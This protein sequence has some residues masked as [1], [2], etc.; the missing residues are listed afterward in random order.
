MD[1]TNTTT[2]PDPAFR[3]ALQ[4]ALGATSVEATSVT[5][6][7]LSN[8]GITDITGIAN[9]TELTEFILDDNQIASIN[10]TSNN[11]L[12][13]LSIRNNR[14]TNGIN[15]TNNP[16]KLASGTPLEKFDATGCTNF[17]A[18]RAMSG[19][20]SIKTLKW[21]SLNGCVAMH[22]FS[23]G[24]SDQTGLKYLDLT[25]SGQADT[26]STDA[27]KL[28]Y[29]NSL[30][31]LI[32]LETLI[33]AN[34]AS[35][36]TADLTK[37]TK[38]KYLDM[39]G[40]KLGTAFNPAYPKSLE[41]LILANNSSLRYTN[42][43]GCENLKYLDMSGNDMYWGTQTNSTNKLTPANCP[44]LEVLILDDAKIATA[45]TVDGFQNLKTL[46]VGGS[47]NTFNSGSDLTL[48]NCPAIENINVSGAAN[49][50][51]VAIKN[52]GLTSIPTITSDGCTKLKTLVL[53]GN[54]FSDVPTVG[55]PFTCLS[56]Q[57]NNFPAVYSLSGNTLEGLDLG[58][59]GLTSVTVENSAMSA[60]SLAGNTNLTEVHLHGNANLTKTASDEGI[61]AA[62]GLYIKGLAN[63]ETLDIEN[64]SFE[65]LGQSN[66]TQGC[67][68][69]KT[70]K[71][72][73]NKFTT[74]SNAYTSFSASSRTKDESRSSLE[75]LTGLEYLDLSNNLL[76]DSLHLFKNTQLKTLIVRN[77][78][79]ITEYSDNSVVNKKFHT[80]GDVGEFNDTIGLRMINLLYNPNL[81][82]LDIS[83][84]NIHHFAKDGRKDIPTAHTE[85]YYM[86]NFAT[87]ATE[88]AKNREPHYILVT[89]CNKL[90]EFYAD[91][92]GMKSAAFIPNNEGHY[93]PDLKRISMIET[94][95]QDPHTMQ[96][97][98]NPNG[99]G[100]CPNLEYINVANSDLDSIGVTNNKHLKYLN[101]SG[102]WTKNNWAHWSSTGV[103]HTLNLKGCDA[104]VECVADDCPHLVIAQANDK[105]NLTSL[106][107]NN[108]PELK[109]VYVPNTG[110]AR[111]DK[112]AYNR[113][114][115]GDS[116]S[117]QAQ[118][119]LG[120]AGLNTAANLELLYCEDNA[121]LT[122][123]DVTAN[124]NLKYLHAYNNK[125]GVSGLDLSHNNGLV[126]AWVS[127]SEIK[128][129]NLDGCV[130]LDTLK[131]YDNA[132][133]AELYVDDATNN[134]R[135][136]DLAR[137]HVGDL[138][139]SKNTALEY[140][141]CSND[142]KC[143]AKQGNWIS[144]LNFT[145]TALK[146]VYA[147]N[148]NLYCIKL[149][150]SLPSLTNIEYEHNHIN[151]IDLSGASDGVTIKDQ[152][153]GRTIVAEC[154]NWK[155]QD[156]SA[157]KLFY[158]QL[159][160]NAGDNTSTTYN[161]Y[162][163]SKTSKD[164]LKPTEEY[165]RERL[166]ADGFVVDKAIEWTTGVSGVVNGTKKKAATISDMTPD[167]IVGNIVVL[168][169]TEEPAGGKASG[170]AEYTYNN[171]KGNST[172]YLD[173]TAD[174]QVITGVDD[175]NASTEVASVTYYNLA[176]V[177][178]Q[179]PFDGVNLVVKTMTDGSTVTTKMIK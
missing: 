49:I 148:N 142:E 21:L 160:P 171:G 145:S 32:N 92:N 70:L 174:S 30:P 16:I 43:S 29:A 150:T 103:G 9:F 173:W 41:T 81:E 10:L 91:Y 115:D 97:S 156:K 140:F 170:H 152:D 62:Q 83:Y 125:Y 14:A 137:C 60:L 55:G 51:S 19:T 65:E 37:L 167:Q 11:K 95:G 143:D 112:G 52:S 42:V 71:A 162:L 153:N 119:N 155:K 7:D 89:N 86:A 135:Y 15:S 102:N 77:N 166:N 5:S 1:L 179:E 39:S 111:I 136:L 134:L 31:K 2:F 98:W 133:L 47:K 114:D 158:F 17:G 33:L 13:I 48:I 84:T 36:T 75:H 101:V 26:Q 175:L 124:S 63:L 169:P 56:L 85:D 61:S 88:T 94:R 154:A 35:L 100:G 126:T 129:L 3:T 130:V 128:S 149:P 113:A 132:T 73:H 34:N 104:L 67:S 45:P 177:A 165:T 151:G 123:L 20:Y 27:Y 141:D 25:N 58:N 159:T 144:D 4:Q 54:Q 96:G 122:S 40:C 172:F 110:L 53:D 90:K 79:T 146:E 50:T 147:N 139:V 72:A 64:S 78:R 8:Q 178:S 109:Q 23:S 163:A 80:P 69:L 116:R 22:G 117:Q 28:N 12:I 106:S 108:N 6:L 161:T 138:D 44:K 120:L 121:N 105:T 66:S 74:F 82:Y 38:L 18:F 57:S 118:G 131:C 164:E 24:I 107:L 176:G 99:S 46:S 168:I 127:N 157:T 68:G 87:K 59:N 76:Q 93:F